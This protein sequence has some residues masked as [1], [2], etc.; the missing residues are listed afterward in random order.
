MKHRFYDHDKIYYELL[1]SIEDDFNAGKIT[2]QQR[3][4]MIAKATL[5]ES[6]LRKKDLDIANLM[7]GDDTPRENDTTYYQQKICNYL[8]EKYIS[9]KCT[10]DEL[11]EVFFGNYKYIILNSKHTGAKFNEMCKKIYNDL[12]ANKLD[13]FKISREDLL[14]MYDI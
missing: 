14:K 11:K 4:I 9:C 2:E 8:D 12:I 13:I 3:D 1:D 5:E 6:D 7:F 10:Y